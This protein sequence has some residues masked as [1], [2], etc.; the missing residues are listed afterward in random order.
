[1]RAEQLSRS[2]K[3]TI[4]ALDSRKSVVGEHAQRQREQRSA[5]EGH[6]KEMIDRD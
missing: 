5:T 2:G 3:E 4:H 6:V 1:M